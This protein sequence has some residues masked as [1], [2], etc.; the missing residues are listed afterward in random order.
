MYVGQSLVANK[1]LKKGVCQKFVIKWR[2][3]GFINQMHGDVAAEVQLAADKFLKM[4]SDIIK[5]CHNTQVAEDV[6]TTANSKP[7]AEICSASTLE[8]RIVPDFQR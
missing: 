8:A 6:A 4:H 2:R 1:V 7:E 3:P 5:K